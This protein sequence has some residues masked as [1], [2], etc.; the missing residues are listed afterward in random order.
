MKSKR[1]TS[2]HEHKGCVQ[3]CYLYAISHNIRFELKNIIKKIKIFI[4]FIF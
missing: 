1:L 3:N 2:G 4:F